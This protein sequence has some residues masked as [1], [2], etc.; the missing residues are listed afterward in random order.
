MKAADKT[1]SK[2]YARAYMALD[3]AAFDKHGDAAA[4]A[5][6]EELEKVR[7]AVSQFRKLFLHP[8]VG[9]DD[10]NEILA[11]LLCKECVGD[12]TKAF[13]QQ[14]AKDPLAQQA[15][16]FVRLLLKENRYYL[17]ELVLEDCMRLYNAY[18]G[19]AHAEAVT[20]HPLD[21][22]QLRHIGKILSAATGKKVHVTQIVSER[23]LGGMEIRLGDLLIDDTVRGRLERLKKTILSF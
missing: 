3:G 5:R 23:V 12:V 11:R 1:L 19:L 9:Y 4:R 18:A 14:N 7:N 22:E 6:I 10:K 15:A 8:L 2:R 20:R 13:D 16:A 21:D 17:M